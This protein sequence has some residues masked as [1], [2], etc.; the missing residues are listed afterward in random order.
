MIYEIFLKNFI[1][2]NE[3]VDINRVIAPQPQPRRLFFIRKQWNC[4]NY[5]GLI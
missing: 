3:T 4:N 2:E 5:V 1:I